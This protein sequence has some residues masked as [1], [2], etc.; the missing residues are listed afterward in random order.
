MRA[1]GAFSSWAV[2]HL[3]LHLFHLLP[4]L[5]SEAN[6]KILG[7]DIV[8]VEVIGP[9]GDQTQHPV[10]QGDRRAIIAHRPPAIEL[11]AWFSEDL[12]ELRG[13]LDMFR[14]RRHLLPD[15]SSF[16]LSL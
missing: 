13:G 5:L 1:A 2:A 12:G 16:F 3:A 9:V 10:E 7:Q 15:P 14:R 4:S 11:R 6:E 8:V